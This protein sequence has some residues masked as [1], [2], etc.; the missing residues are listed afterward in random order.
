M[1]DNQI[2]FVDYVREDLI[3][4]GVEG[5]TRDEVLNNISKVLI[6][7]DIVKESFA[8]GLL[9]RE[10]EY[11]TGLPVG[12]YNVAIPHTYPEHNKEIAVT[13]AVPKNPVVFL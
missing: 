12:E 2:Q 6:E 1:S 4:L 13:I 5:N 8:E 10:N 7:K 11:P 9:K 3:L